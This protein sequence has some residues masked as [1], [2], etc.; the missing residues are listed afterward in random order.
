MQGRS[1]GIELSKVE[2]DLVVTSTL[3]RS[4]EDLEAWDLSDEAIVK[5]SVREYERLRARIE[6]A[7]KRARW[8][9]SPLEI[10][11]REANLWQDTHP[12]AQIDRSIEKNRNTIRHYVNVVKAL[13]WWSKV[14]HSS[15]KYPKGYPLEHLIEQ[16]C[17]DGIGSVAEGVTRMLE[18]VLARYRDA[19]PEGLE[20]MEGKER[21]T[22]Y[23]ALGVTVWAARTKEDPIRV[24]FGALGGEE[25]CRSDATST[26]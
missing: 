25:V 4:V 8:Q 26:R 12:L 22:V 3:S 6:T 2:L 11:D 23:N 18:K 9:L 14:N 19:G 20:K 21:C 1:I 16:C 7:L 15:P 24:V 10:P 17:P 5:K 13:K